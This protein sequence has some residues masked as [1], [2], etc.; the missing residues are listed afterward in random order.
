MTETSGRDRI[1]WH[2]EARRAN[3]LRW[4]FVPAL[5]HLVMSVRATPLGMRGVL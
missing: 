1:V 3:T 4:Q 2:R 5:R